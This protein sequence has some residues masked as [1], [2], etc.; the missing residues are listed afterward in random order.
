[1]TFEP[2]AYVKNGYIE[3]SEKPEISKIIVNE[4]YEQ[5]LDGISEYSHIIVIFAFDKIINRNENV[6]LKGHARGRKDMP[7]VG[8]FSLRT[9][10]RPNPIGVTTVKLISVEKNILTVEG[11]DAFDN[12]PVL[13]IKP[14][15][16]IDLVKDAKFP[17][18]SRKIKNGV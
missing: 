2:I 15:G 18:W 5:A 1:M 16:I 10:Y 11:L 9:P 13:D 3:K 14:Y 6:P 4:K 8:I 7:L 12:T 17:A